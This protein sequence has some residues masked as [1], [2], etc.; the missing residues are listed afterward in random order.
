[1]SIP[2]EPLED[3]IADRAFGDSSSRQLFD[4]FRAL[5]GSRAGRSLLQVAGVDPRR[6]D[7][8]LTDHDR[9][10]THV[11]AV[12][13]AFA[14]AG[15]APTGMMPTDLYARA[16]ETLETEQSM[17]AAEAVLVE[18]WEDRMDHLR[19]LAGWISGLGS[20]EREYEAIF[21]HRARLVG[22]ALDHHRAGA[23]EASIPILLAQIEG[24]TADV[25]GGKMF[26]SKQ[27]ARM[28]EVVDDATIAGLHEALP[29]VRAWFSEGVAT[30][31]L[32]EEA[33]RH[34]ILHGRILRYDTQTNSIKCIVLL[35]AVHEWAKPL[36]QAEAARRRGEH[37][38][39]Y[40]GSPDVDENGRRLDD[41]EFRETQR[42]LQWLYTCQIGQHGNQG[43][44]PP[45]LN[46][47]LAPSFRDHGLPAEHG[48]ELRVSQDGQSWWA[49]RRTPSRQIL[50]IGAV[51]DPR[52]QW[53]YDAA[54]HPDG[55]PAAGP[56][57]GEAPFALHPN[58]N[59]A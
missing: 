26:F 36:A 41:R 53:L 42:A 19:L 33:S 7:A 58:W 22:R 16:L 50:G 35:C 47:R 18:G 8:T 59:P 25:T 32:T 24:I 3:R 30:T 2:S 37:E 31:V 54:S 5:A 13:R 52:V 20:G 27:P 21:A 15:W 29:T 1:M 44:F 6:F 28:A 51:G 46:V 4:A 57:W 45:D 12:V 10:V 17:Q 56:G 11:A 48:I 43:R 40:E 55:P 14:S 23:Y 39:A 49:W 9:L 34:G 38:A